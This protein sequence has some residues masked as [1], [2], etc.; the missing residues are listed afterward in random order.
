MGILAVWLA[1]SPPPH[2]AQSPRATSGSLGVMVARRARFELRAPGARSVLCD[3]AR[4]FPPDDRLVV[5]REA[6]VHVVITGPVGRTTALN[7]PV[8]LL[9]NHVEPYQPVR[10]DVQGAGPRS[11]TDLRAR[12]VAGDVLA[13]F[14]VDADGRAVPA[15]ARILRSSHQGLASAA[16]ENLVR[17]VFIPKRLGGGRIGARISQPFTFAVEGPDPPL[18]PDTGTEVPH[19]SRRPMANPSNP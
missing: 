18:L 15:S 10:P 13:P 19:D 4:V 17:A 1:V 6:G 11:P 14:V 7:A 5:A 16:R 3:S 9:R 12:G 8:L 2:R